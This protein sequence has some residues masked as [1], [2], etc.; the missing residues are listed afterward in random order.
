MGAMLAT[1]SLRRGGWG[2]KSPGD[3]GNCWAA[4]VGGWN[5]AGRGARVGEDLW[6]QRWRAAAL[7]PEEAEDEKLFCDGSAANR[8]E[9]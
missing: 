5:T 6:R 8:K 7:E 3:G 1:G 2:Q 4:A 9:R